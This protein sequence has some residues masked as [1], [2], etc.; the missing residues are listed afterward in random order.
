MERER[1]LQSVEDGYESKRDGGGMNK[2]PQRFGMT[3]MSKDFITL[4]QFAEAVKIQAG[5]DLDETETSSIIIVPDH[6]G[7]PIHN[8]NVASL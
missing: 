7:I 5:E 3:A 6:R 2:E 4:E 1:R 8:R